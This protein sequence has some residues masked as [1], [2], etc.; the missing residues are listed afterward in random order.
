MR[1]RVRV[2]LAEDSLLLRG[3]AAGGI[4]SRGGHRGRGRPSAARGGV[5]H[6]PDVAIIDVR[7]PPTFTDLEVVYALLSHLRIFAKLGFAPSGDG[8]RRVR[9]VLT[10]LGA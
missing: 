10:W 7:M 5:A 1:V 6:R 2:V 4:R 9:A 8:H 3:S